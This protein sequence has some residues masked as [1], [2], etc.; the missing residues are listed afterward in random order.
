MDTFDRKLAAQRKALMTVPAP[1]SPD[2]QQAKHQACTGT[3]AAW[4]HLK[5]ELADCTCF[6][7]QKG[8]R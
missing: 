7:H 5:D 3:Q 2:C 1:T 6:C 4:D 8:R